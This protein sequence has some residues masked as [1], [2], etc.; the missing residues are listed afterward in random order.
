MK[1]KRAVGILICIALSLLATTGFV[2][3][4]DQPQ[5]TLRVSPQTSQLEIGE[6][7]TVDLRI[8]QV[9]GLYG[10]EV[11]LRFDPDVL[12]VV[13]ADSAQDGIQLEPG[14][15]PAPD[16]IVQN[17]ADNSTGTIDYAVTQLPPSKPS[18]GEGTIA[19]VIFR[20]KKAAVSQ[21]QFEQFL[22]AD[23]AGSNINAVPQHGQIKVQSSPPWMFIAAAGMAL[24]LIA[25]SIGFTLKRRK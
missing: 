5:T 22:L 1:S 13:D 23:T 20:A 8:A 17:Y 18:E 6:T 9:Y 12:E 21:I 7:T 4:L 19:R 15:L 24:L 16:F 10:I 14:T 11:H 3:H 25:G 2:W